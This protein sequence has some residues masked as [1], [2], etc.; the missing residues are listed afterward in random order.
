MGAPSQHLDVRI[1]QFAF[2]TTLAS[3]DTREHRGRRGVIVS[4]ELPRG[5]DHI[6]DLG[7]RVA[8][9]ERAPVRESRH[10][11]DAVTLADRK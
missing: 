5:I 10:D 2:D 4:A 7:K 6:R 8:L 9:T 1:A 11:T 3:V